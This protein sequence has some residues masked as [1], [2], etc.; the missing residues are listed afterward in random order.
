MA[1]FLQQFQSLDMSSVFGCARYLNEQF[2]LDLPFNHITALDI[3]QW[4]SHFR[5]SAEETAWLTERLLEYSVQ[6]SVQYSVSQKGVDSLSPH[7][8]DYI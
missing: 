2:R 4:F 8:Y 1:Q 3:V 5:N 7:L 6:C